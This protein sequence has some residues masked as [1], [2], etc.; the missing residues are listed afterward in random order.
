[1]VL[2]ISVAAGKGKRSVKV[3][4]PKQATGM[5]GGAF[6][7]KSAPFPDTAF[8][9]LSGTGLRFAGGPLNTKVFWQNK[10]P[11]NLGQ[12]VLFSSGVEGSRVAP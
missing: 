12:V 9:P 11:H 5:P 2:D 6:S 7:S 10:C 8:S 3:C 4:V 1:M